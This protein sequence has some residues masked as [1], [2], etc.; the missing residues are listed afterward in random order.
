MLTRAIAHVDIDQCSDGRELI[1]LC[2]SDLDRALRCE[3]QISDLTRR[4]TEL[5]STSPCNGSLL[6]LL[7]ET[8]E[9]WQERKE[10]LTAPPSARQ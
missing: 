6:A 10:R 4:I 3:Q 1:L 5:K 2:M 7:Q 8:L 9:T